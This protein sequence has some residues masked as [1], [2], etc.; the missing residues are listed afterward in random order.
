MPRPRLPV[1]THATLDLSDKLIDRTPVV[2]RA[3][4][5][6][7]WGLSMAR[8]MVVDDD[9]HV[10]YAL[11][12]TFKRDVEIVAYATIREAEAHA[13]EDWDGLII[14]RRLT[15][16]DGLVFAKRVVARHARASI[17]LFT[18]AEPHEVFEETNRHGIVYAHKTDGIAV[19]KRMVATWARAAR[20]P[21][22]RSPEIRLD[23]LARLR[24]LTSREVDIARL[25]QRGLSRA[26][27]SDQLEISPN[28]HRNLVSGLLKKTGH[29]RLSGLVAQLS[30]DELGGT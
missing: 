13:E 14:D 3:S 9:R 8:V 16:G 7:E 5:E 25:A 19:L 23:E 27:A 4:D 29:R 24:A 17:V 1:V 22:E 15:D 10:R 18:A 2:R 12:A 21:S 30:K 11:V 26:E 6:R 20:G 28:T